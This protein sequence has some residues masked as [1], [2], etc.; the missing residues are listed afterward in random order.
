M[1]DKELLLQMHEHLISNF[2]LSKELTDE[3]IEKKIEEEIFYSGQTQYIS[4][5]DKLSYKKALF[6][7]LRGLDVLQEL[8][9]NPNITEI[10][11][12][13]KDNIF[14]EAFGNITYTNI[15]FSSNE[16]LH[17]VVNQI[18]GYSN[19]RVN[20]TTPIADA[21]LRDG[22]RVNI[23][24]P[25]ISLNG[26]VITIR[27]FPKKRITMERLIELGSITENAAHFLELLVLAG[28]NIFVS[29]GT[30]SGKTTFLN[31]LSNAIPSDSRVITIEDSAELQLQN[32]D[33][34]VRLEARSANLEGTGE[35][36]IRDL[37]RTS[38]R[39]RPDRL[40]IGEVRGGEAFDMIQA[41]NTGHSG[42]MSTGHANSSKDM[43]TRLETMILMGA[44]L[45]IPAIRGQIFAAIDIIV[46][47][48]RLRDKS[49]KVLEI[50]ELVDFDGNEIKLQPIYVFEE[51][52]FEETKKPDISTTLNKT[53][54]SNQSNTITNNFVS[55]KV[56]GKLTY[57]NTPLTNTLKLK[58]AGL[59]EPV[60]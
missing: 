2:D 29:G 20:E 38:L 26:P 6:N 31:V 25:P 46:H 37:I 42:S 30:G 14:Y 60:Y 45:P 53:D 9:D 18:T 40:V 10:M 47:L 24:L 16:K 12:N 49:R 56:I 55:N 15:S 22:S 19:R 52:K 58:M 21:R 33:N 8:I 28:Y 39:M 13:G 3:E 57:T 36:S 59:K 50:S 11:V 1:I 43:L 48:G 51:T 5:N 4:I 23:V 41:F 32:I 7:S 17:D 27:K 35:I 54:C 44:N 34:L